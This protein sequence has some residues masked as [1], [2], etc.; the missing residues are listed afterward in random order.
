MVLLESAGQNSLPCLAQLLQATHILWLVAPSSILK[1][2][3]VSSADF[4]LTP[5]SIIHHLFTFFCFPLKILRTLMVALG[6][7]G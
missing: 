5:A 3:C 7:S 2:S 1:A 6:W 4:P